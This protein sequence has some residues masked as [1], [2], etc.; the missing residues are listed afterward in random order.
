MTNLSPHLVL[1]FVLAAGAG[2]AMTQLGYGSRLLRIEL[3]TCA[4]CGRHL[5]H[6]ACSAL[7]RLTRRLIMGEMRQEP[8]APT[9]NDG[10]PAAPKQSDPRSPAKPGKGRRALVWA[11]VVV[12]SLLMFASVLT[13]WVDRQMLD[14][15]NWNQASEQVIQDPAV[16]DALSVY[17]VNQLYDNVDVE[18]AL[19]QKLPPGLQGLAGPAAG[20]LRQPA[21]NAVGVILQ[22]PR[23][24]QAWVSAMTVAH[25]KLLNVLEDKTGNGISTGN[26]VVTLDLSELVAE[27]G[28][29]LGVPQ[30]ALDRLPPDAG[31]FTLMKSDQ[32]S[33]AQSGFQVLKALSLWLLV[34]VLVMYGLAIYLAR[35]FRRRTL[36]NIGWAFVVVG[37]LTIIARRLLGNYTVDAVAAPGYELVGHHAW[38]IGTSI[39]GEIGRSLVLYGLVGVLGAVL[40]G[41]TRLATG[42][43]RRITPTLND[44]PEVTWGA[45]GGVFLLLVLWGGTHA[46]R[47]WW[48]ILLLGGLLALGVVALRR[49]T[50][51]EAAAAEAAP[52]TAPS[53]RTAAVAARF[54]AGQKRSAA[55]EIASLNDLRASGAISEEEYERGKELALR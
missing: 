42:L 19:A 41:P 32:L 37:L 28:I 24:Q 45:V 49:Q 21:T 26:G 4:S 27:L 1:L 15:D 50:L 18:Q 53:S 7:R 48:G 29:D 22:R 8:A 43:R 10:A 33:A 17:L 40:A 20:A 31:Q 23:V 14:N 9:P 36:R 47:E 2:A 30:A 35:G 55:D 51:A 3:K 44:Q 38:L 12:A 39:L 5:R 16:Q 54:G 13:K 52:A 34:L 11:L 25:Q 6:G 46:L